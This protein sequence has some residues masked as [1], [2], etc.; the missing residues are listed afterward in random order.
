L[1]CLADFDEF[2][3]IRESFM[4]QFVSQE[5][6]EPLILS[7]MTSATPVKST[8]KTPMLIDTI[9]TKI[10]YKSQPTPAE[11]QASLQALIRDAYKRRNMMNDAELNA[12]GTG[13]LLARDRAR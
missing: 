1:L 13:G 9:S 3:Q 8:S 10:E 2:F 12:K 4:R 11:V 6:D 7:E 5:I